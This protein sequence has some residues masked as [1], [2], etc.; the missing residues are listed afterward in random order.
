MPT[1][2]NLQPV[3]IQI[4]ILLIFA[5]H[6]LIFI[7]FGNT[8][9][10]IQTENKTK[11]LKKIKATAGGN[12]TKN[13]KTNTVPATAS[14]TETE[15]DFP[16]EYITYAELLA[17]AGNNNFLRMYVLSVYDRPSTASI[18]L[19]VCNNVYKY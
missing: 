1:L 5:W 10:T 7:E 2:W 17:A 11:D 16:D 12:K 4:H 13:P 9:F 6:G 3:W 18:C 19:T 8:W 15:E 14:E